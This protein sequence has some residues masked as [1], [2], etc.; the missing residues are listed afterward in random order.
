MMITAHRRVML[1]DRLRRKRLRGLLHPP[2]ELGIRRLVLFDVILDRLFIEPERGA[3]HRIKTFANGGIT[4]SE[5]TR[6]FQGN[7]LPEP[8]E[9]HNAEWPIRAGTNQWNVG[10]AHNFDRLMIQSHENN[11]FQPRP[12]QLVALWPFGEGGTLNFLEKVSGGTLEDTKRIRI[13]KP[14]NQEE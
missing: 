14:V 5:F 3:S 7:F 4:G 9:M 13:R 2:F 12:Q 11:R 6:R 8:R 10:G 1:L